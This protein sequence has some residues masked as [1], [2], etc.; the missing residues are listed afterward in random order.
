MTSNKS[1]TATFTLKEVTLTMAV[2]GTGSGTV[3][4]IVGVH[5]YN[6]GDTVTISAT[7]DPSSVFDGWSGDASGTSDVVL[8]MTSNKSVTATFTADIV[9]EQKNLHANLS[10]KGVVTEDGWNLHVWAN[11]TNTSSQIFI[12]KMRIKSEQEGTGIT[13]FY[14]SETG[15]E[16]ISIA[17]GKGKYPI[18]GDYWLMDEVATGSAPK[19]VFVEIWIFDM[20]NNIIAYTSKYAK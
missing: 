17:P 8:T 6:Y 14:P 10:K 9:I 5:T 11:I 15:Y 13:E 12:G 16:P 19:D 4:P 3:N 18:I 1:V 20:S 2:A 7:A